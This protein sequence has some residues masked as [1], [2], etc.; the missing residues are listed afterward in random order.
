MRARRSLRRCTFTLVVLSLLAYGVSTG[1][2]GAALFAI[3]LASG[4]WW[5]TEGKHG[6]AAPRWVI[7]T[8]LVLVIARGLWT[9]SLRPATSITPFL[10]FLTSI[11]VVKCWERRGPR[12]FAQMLSIAAF[13]LIG[14]ALGS[15]SFGTGL[16]IAVSFPVLVHGAIMLQIE[17]A[18]AKAEQLGR[19]AADLG[20]IPRKGTARFTLGLAM[21]GVAFA[22][23]VFVVVPRTQGSPGLAALGLAGARVSGFRDRVE[24]GRA[25]LINMSQVVVME[26]EV[27]TGEGVPNVARPEGELY[28]RGAVLDT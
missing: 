22:A 3:A 1:G 12:D 23:G 26:V 10:A 21:L 14:S 2:I 8:L 16:I 17:A 18:R 7:A 24:L 4:G 27:V 6:W 9:L 11:V 15:N 20:D 28:L 13:V 19:H 5:L 25:G